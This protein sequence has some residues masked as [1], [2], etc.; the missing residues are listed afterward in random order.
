MYTKVK[1]KEE[2]VAMRDSGVML[3]HVLRYVKDQ[4]APGMTTQEASDLAGV[5][6]KRLGGKP[7]FLGYQGFPE[8]LCV[9]VND[10]V[11]HGI[12]RRSTVIRDGDI[13]SMDFGVEYK[14][15]ITDSAI[16]EIVGSANAADEK[17]LRATKKSLDAG[18]AVIKDGV[19][20]GDIA[21]AVQAV[22]DK[23]GYGIVR[24][25]VGH[26]V[27]HQVHEEPNIPNYGKAGV[28][29]ALKAGMTVAIEP[30]ATIGH[31]AIQIDNDGWTVRTRDGSR[32]AHF[33]HTVLVTTNGVEILTRK[34]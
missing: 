19:R 5:E 30:M 28:G 8:P 9:S 31:H 33:E 22:L 25:L 29:P 15:M 1:T 10:E 27:G 23:A 12:P 3:A 24:E 11:V 20:V 4:L 14:G 34:S 32:S 26:G 17:L 18:L 2:I 16:S 6:L 13:V 7:A 21:A